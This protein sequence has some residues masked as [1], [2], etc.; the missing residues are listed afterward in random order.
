[1]DHSEPR[2]TRTTPTNQADNAI[3][4]VNDSPGYTGWEKRASMARK[5]AGS[6]P[7]SVW[8]SARPVKPYVQRP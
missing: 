2:R 1:M 8:R 7:Q 5:R 3:D 4:T 6:E